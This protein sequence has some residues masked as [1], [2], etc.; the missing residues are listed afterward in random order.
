M[1]R[2]PVISVIVP[3]YKVE[4][5]I[6]R[7]VDSIL[8][9]SFCD[10]ELILVDDGSPDN[11]G[12]ICDAYAE[13]D[14]RVH[15]IHQPNS[16]LSGARNAGIDWVFANS[17][18]RWITFVDS[19]DW[20]HC[21]MLEILLNAVKR[22]DVRIG[23]CGFVETS[24]E[25][26]REMEKYPEHEIWKPDA[27]YV[28]RHVPATIA[29]AKLYDRA[30]FEECRYPI[31]RIHEDE[32]VTY[33]LLFK[34]QQ[35]V[36]V[37]VPLYYYYMN[38]ASITK[39]RWTPKRLDALDAK[40]EQLRFFREKENISMYRFCLRNYLETALLQREE[41]EKQSGLLNDKNLKKQLDRK[42]RWLIREN[43]NQGQIHIWNDYECLRRYY[44]VPVQLYRI[45]NA[46]RK[47]LGLK[48]DA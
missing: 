2:K 47:R 18:S 46:V 7:C 14:S 6:H 11:C 22:A 37:S 13:K 28:Q 32:F 15:V 12:A 25:E 40:E 3:V 36:Y 34:C 33:H 9:Q 39:S 45:Y 5:F 35:V 19:D 48:Y 10:F 1:S 27:F 31:G 26:L 17:D 38:T 23:I 29:C 8:N 24:G 42:I 44:P 20:V 30:L 4:P 16:G 41:M 21:R 43:R